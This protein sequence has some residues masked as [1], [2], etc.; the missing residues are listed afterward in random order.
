MGAGAGAG[1]AA[2][3]GRDLHA[4]L[5]AAQVPGPYVLLGASFGGLI[6]D[7]YAATYPDQVVGMV[8][9]DASLLDLA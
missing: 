8:L 1:S 2:S 6:A 3:R 4:L 9:L 5:E 7:M